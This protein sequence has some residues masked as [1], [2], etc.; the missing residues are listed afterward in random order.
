MKPGFSIDYEKQ[1]KTRQLLGLNY[2]MLAGLAFTLTAWG[3]DAFQLARASADFFWLKLVIGGLAAL[4]L[5]GL[6]GWL[7]E[8]IDSGLVT[9]VLWL[10]AAYL[11]ARLASHLPFEIFSKSIAALGPNLQG[12]TVYPYPSNVDR[13]MIIIYIVVLITG[14][15]G[16]ALQSFLVDS[17]LGAATTFNRC[18]AIGVCVPFFLLAGNAVDNLNG[19]LRGSLVVTHEVIEFARANQGKPVDPKLAADLSLPSVDPLQSLLNRPYR[20]ILGTYEPENLDF[21]LFT[22]ISMEHGLPAQLWSTGSPI[23]T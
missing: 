21:S 15:L 11:L 8:K 22:S 17:A 9:F 16:G 5:G 2:G 1:N 6:V 13:R 20:L 23:A 4:F 14:G 19:A 18:L 10:A 12:L 7:G 3:I